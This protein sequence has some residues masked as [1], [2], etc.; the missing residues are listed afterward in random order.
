MK[1][2]YRNS[3]LID[4]TIPVFSFID[5]EYEITNCLFVNYLRGLIEVHS[6]MTI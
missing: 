1:G 3:E 4:F 2:H 6:L 5:F